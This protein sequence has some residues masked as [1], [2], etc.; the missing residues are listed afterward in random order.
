VSHVS[1]TLDPLVVWVLITVPPT[2]TVNVFDEPLAPLTQITIQT[3]PL[4]VA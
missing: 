4:T 1:L 3:V 2:E